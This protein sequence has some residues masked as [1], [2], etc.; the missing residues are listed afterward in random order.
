MMRFVWIGL[1]AWLVATVAIRSTGGQVFRAGTP[2]H[3]ALLFGLTALAIALPI[4]LLVRRLPSRDAGLRAVALIILPGMLLDAGS[5]LWF[6][7]VFPNM[8]DSA[9]MPFASLLLWAYGIALLTG[10]WPRRTTVSQAP[11]NG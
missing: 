2:V 4:F 7:S 11:R 9:G 8:P 1:C 5:V 3:A 6:R 10:V